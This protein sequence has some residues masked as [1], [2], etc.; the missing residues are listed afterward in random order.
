MSEETNEQLSSEELGQLAKYL[1]Q[2][3]S[4]PMPD[5]KHNVHEF[6]HSVATET[7]TTKVG[8]LKEEELGNPKHPVRGFKEFALISKSIIGND[9]FKDY[10]TAESEIV[11]ASSLSREGFLVKQATTTTKQL[12]DITKKAKTQNKSWFKKKDDSE[13]DKLQT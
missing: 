4:A 6:L 1:S 2:S 10:F 8:F 5:Q 11:T 7:D 13:G 9:Y 12:A 3:D